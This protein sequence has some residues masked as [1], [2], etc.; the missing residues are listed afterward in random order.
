MTPTTVREKRSC[1]RCGTEFSSYGRQYLCRVCRAPR[2]RIGA[3]ERRGK[4]LS[5]RERQVVAIVAEGHAN[6]EIGARLH[7]TEG[8]IKEY[9]NRIFVKTGCE[10]R[11]ALALWAHCQACPHGASPGVGLVNPQPEILSSCLT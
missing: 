7:L 9:L 5:A 11:V 10:N 4:A 1:C 6:K 2:V 3:A 8:T